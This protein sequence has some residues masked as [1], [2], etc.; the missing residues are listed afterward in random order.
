MPEP[1]RVTVELD[2]ATAAMLRRRC[3]T[4]GGSLAAAAAA[5]LAEDAR[6]EM[7][8]GLPAWYGRHEA[9]VLAAVEDGEAALSEAV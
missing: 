4:R 3:V 8:G 7:L 9:E 6:R 5:Q 2:A 1:E